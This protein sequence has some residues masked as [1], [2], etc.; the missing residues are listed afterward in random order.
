VV[1]TVTPAPEDVQR[2]ADETERRVARM[3]C[4]PRDV[5]SRLSG[6]PEDVLTR[7]PAPDAWSIT[8][9]VCHLRDV[10]E[11][12]LTRVRFILA[13]CD[14]VLIAFSPDRWAA[15]RQYRRCVWRPALAA[16]VARREETLSVLATLGEDAWERGGTH[17]LRGWMTVRR[18]VHGWAK[19]DTEHTD[20]VDRALDGRP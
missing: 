2:L 10:E 8:E 19:H 20:Q 18:I 5:S 3:R 7:R 15:E 4:A 14:P 6:C 17:S 9:I 1:S 12:Y 16:F 13:N 11:F